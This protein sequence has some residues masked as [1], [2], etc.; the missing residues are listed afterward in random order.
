MTGLFARLSL[1]EFERAPLGFLAWF[2][3]PSLQRNVL[4]ELMADWGA[5]TIDQAPVEVCA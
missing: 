4:Q 2:F 5:G 3:E 1:G